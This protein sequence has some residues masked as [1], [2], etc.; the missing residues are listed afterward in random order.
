MSCGYSGSSEWHMI[1][2]MKSPC[3]DLF[4]LYIKLCDPIGRLKELQIEVF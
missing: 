4:T 2:G 1:L 3:V